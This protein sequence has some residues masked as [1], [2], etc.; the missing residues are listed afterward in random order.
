MLFR[1]LFIACLAS[2]ILAP[3]LNSQESSQSGCEELLR[4]AAEI[5]PSNPF[6]ADVD[7]IYPWKIPGGSLPLYILSRAVFRAG[8]ISPPSTRVGEAEI[9]HLKHLPGVWP[10]GVLHR[11]IA[12]LRSF[13]FEA[14]RR[15][16]IVAADD[17]AKLEQQENQLDSRR[18][19]YFA[20]RDPVTREVL[21]I[22]R[23]FDGSLFPGL[24][25]GVYGGPI[26]ENRDLPLRVEV[27]GI[28]IPELASRE[29][30]YEIGR[31]AINSHDERLNFEA[32]RVLLFHVSYFIRYKF[33]DEGKPL[34]EGS[35]YIL[36]TGSSAR[37]YKRFGF[38]PARQDAMQRP[39]ERRDLRVPMK[40]SLF[41]F[42]NRYQDRSIFDG[43]RL[44]DR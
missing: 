11:E 44:H 12:S 5:Q 14:Y 31:L 37:L 8:S 29:A 7:V 17:I 4:A 21:G 13:S 33:S 41:D 40:M 42:L 15:R 10:Y 27:P 19:I 22:I 26:L 24:H 1:F 18:L 25:R 43:N 2:L 6:Q 16:E 34:E 35:V 38:V 9:D 3:E 32:L 36:A 30:V 23:L 28:V 39:G 20:L